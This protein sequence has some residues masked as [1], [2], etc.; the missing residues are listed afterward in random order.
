MTNPNLISRATINDNDLRNGEIIEKNKET[1]PY[2]SVIN[3]K[4][5]ENLQDKKQF[6]E[7]DCSFMELFL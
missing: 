5:N 7:P 2:D 4:F 3:E 1:V 6:Y